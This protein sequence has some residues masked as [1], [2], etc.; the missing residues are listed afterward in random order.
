MIKTLELKERNN[1][2]GTVSGGKKCAATNV[3]LYG[4]N[5]YKRIGRLGGLKSTTGGFASDKV[6]KDGLTGKQRAK[7]AGAVGGKR[8]KRGPARKEMKD[9]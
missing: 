2:V 9:E 7:I 6:G 5:Y 8:S 4:A 3:A 1:V